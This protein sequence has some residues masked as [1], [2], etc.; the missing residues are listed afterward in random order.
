MLEKY[1]DINQSKLEYDSIKYE[2]LASK[3]NTTFADIVGLD[4]IKQEIKRYVLEPLNNPLLAE[5]NR[6]LLYGPIGCGK[7]LIARA[8]ANEID[9]PFY[10]IDN[11]DISCGLYYE[12]NQNINKI[13]EIALKHERVVFYFDTFDILAYQAANQE[14]KMA[15]KTFLSKIDDF[16]K[17]DNNRMAI[18]FATSNCPWEIDKSILNDFI[19][20]YMPIPDQ[21]LRE[22][23]VSKAL[24]DLPIDDDVDIKTIA[25][26][27][28]D[29]NSADIIRICND[30]K[31]NAYCRALKSGTIQNISINDCNKEISNFS[32]LIYNENIIKNKDFKEKGRI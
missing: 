19:K 12:P 16:N 3:I 2:P 21:S 22:A 5:N 6:I 10:E 26:L 28:A 31:S 18:V 32:N 30:I 17:S 4:D 13:L 20:C 29:C 27:L 14:I 8:I 7:T 11:V 24:F 23:L 15:L 25:K 9:A 1:M